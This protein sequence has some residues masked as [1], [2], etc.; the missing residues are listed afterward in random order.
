MFPHTRTVTHPTTTQR[1]ASAVVY[2]RLLVHGL[3]Y[4][5]YACAGAAL[6]FRPS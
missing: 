2:G 3:Q 4:D 1:T 6:L 5:V